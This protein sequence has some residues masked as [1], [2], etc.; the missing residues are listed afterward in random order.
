MPQVASAA[1]TL[2]GSDADACG[3]LCTRRADWAPWL[4]DELRDNRHARHRTPKDAR[5]PFMLVTGWLGGGPR[6]H[7]LPS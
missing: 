7:E 6:R 2:Y 4:S 5:G 1:E 3:L